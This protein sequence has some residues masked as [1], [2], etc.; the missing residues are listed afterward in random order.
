MLTNEAD[1]KIWQSY[2]TPD[3]VG[4]STFGLVA[5]EAAYRDGESWLGDVMVRLD[6]NASLLGDLI[7][8]HL[9]DLR[10]RRPEATYLAW[11]DFSPY[12]LTEPAEFLLRVAR[13]ALTGGGPFGSGAESFARLNFATHPETLVELC[14]RMGKVLTRV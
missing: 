9:P 5:S 14:E 13:V 1:R 11:L 12:H 4:V 6:S 10:Y 8:E 7:A 3:R 2:F